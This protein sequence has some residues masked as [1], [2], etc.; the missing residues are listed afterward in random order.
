V[1][2]AWTLGTAIRIEAPVN[3]FP[4]H[5]DARPATLLAGGIG[6]TPLLSMARALKQ[7]NTPF[8]LHAIARS[9]GDL[10]YNAELNAEFARQTR[11]HFTRTGDGQRPDLLKLL[12]EAVADS[13][14]YACGP[15]SLLANVRSCATS[16]NL[17]PGRLQLESFV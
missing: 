1:H 15:S 4:L 2:G 7:R 14:I 10:P 3:H 16:L 6:I 12:R 11:F 8:V 17:A 5:D 13:V 9:P